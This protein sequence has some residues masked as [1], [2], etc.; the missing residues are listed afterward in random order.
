MKLSAHFYLLNDD[1]SPEYAEANHGGQESENNP[2]YQW[3]DEL[4]VDELE[5]VVVCENG[6]YTLAGETDQIG[7]FS[8]EL[9]NMLV[10]ELQQS[11]GIH[12]AFALSN[13][14]VNHFELIDSVDGKELK[15]FIKDYEPLTNPI[16]G[17]YIAAKQFPKELITE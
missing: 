15:V 9:S 14:L 8:F 2:F 6:S 12:G 7:T 4:E 13:S 17:V 5:D 11:N 16:P 1:F 10:F 3:E